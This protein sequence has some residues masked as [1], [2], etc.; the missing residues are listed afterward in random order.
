MLYGMEESIMATVKKESFGKLSDGREVFLYTL[1]NTKGTEVAVT[2]Y[3]ARLVK[4]AA[5]DK[6]FTKRDI[7]LGYENA[8]QYEKDTT[9]MGGVV[10]RHANRIA[11]GKVTLGG[12]EYQLEL[13]TGSKKQNHIHGGLKGFH[14]QLWEAEEVYEGVKLTYHAKDGEG[15]Y[16][17]NMTVSVL[18]SLSNDNELSLRYEAVSDADTVCNLTNHAYFNLDGFAAGPEAM[19]NQ[20]IQ[21]MADT[22][23]WADEESLPDGRILEVQGTPMDLRVPLRIGAH[24]DDDFEELKFG[25]G[26]DHNWVIRDKPVELELKP[27]MFGFDP[28][29]PIDYNEGGLK[30]AAYAESDVSGLTLTCYTT[31]PGIQFYSGN[32]LKGGLP[33]KE[34]V[35]FMRRSGF[36]LET[37]YFPNAFANPNFPQPILKKGETWKAQTVY[38][39]AVK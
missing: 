5:R 31:L 14:C 15:G 6:D 24:I 26:Y 32:F 19:L 8:E 21:I 13:N 10:G 7:V 23:T 11:G 35:E 29:C 39:L 12:K 30:K 16:P 1:R 9:S 25:H 28:T 2:T 37:Q 20:R 27:G 18:Y 22:Y 3:G 34:G 36:C 4:F 17:G 38:V 33:G